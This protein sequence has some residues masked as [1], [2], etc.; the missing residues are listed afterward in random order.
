MGSPHWTFYRF[1]EKNSRV[2]TPRQGESEAVSLPS[3]QW[4]F[5]CP[6]DRLTLHQGIRLED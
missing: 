4:R 2:S 3:G 5:Q 6:S 1:W